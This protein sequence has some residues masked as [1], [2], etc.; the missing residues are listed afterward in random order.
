MAAHWEGVRGAC[1]DLVVSRV[2]SN[3]EFLGSLWFSVYGWFLGRGG[4]GGRTCV[5]EGGDGHTAH[6]VLQQQTL[7]GDQD[8]HEGGQGVVER[9][10]ADLGNKNVIIKAGVLIIGSMEGLPVFGQ[11]LSRSSLLWQVSSN[12]VL[13]L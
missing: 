5:E 12:C 7:S 9:K 11:I 8:G 2:K 10:V 6:Q 1:Y 13:Q 4:G 3:F